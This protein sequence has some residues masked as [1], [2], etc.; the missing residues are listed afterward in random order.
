MYD[1]DQEYD[2]SRPTINA[3]LKLALI[4]NEEPQYKVAQRGG[5]SESRF[6]RIVTGRSEP[7]PEERRNV[8][9]ALGVRES[10]LF[11]GAVD[12]EDDRPCPFG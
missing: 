5:L 7:S 9:R 12:L 3:K 4:V 2:P 8:S 11:E 1:L 6:S 10:D